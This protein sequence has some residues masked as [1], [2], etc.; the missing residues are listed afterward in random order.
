MISS[1]RKA[2]PWILVL[3]L[4]GCVCTVLAAAAAFLVGLLPGGEILSAIQLGFAVAYLVGSFLLF[5]FAR[6][7]QRIR[8][9]TGA[10]PVEEALEQQHKVLRLL[11]IAAL[12]QLALV[13]LVISAALFKELKEIVPP[14]EA[15]LPPAFASIGQACSP[16]AA[17]FVCAT[18]ALFN[19]Q[20]RLEHWTGW[21]TFTAD[22]GSFRMSPERDGGVRVTFQ[23][24]ESA[25]SWNVM[26]RPPW[27]NVLMRGAYTGARLSYGQARAEAGE[28]ELRTPHAWFPGESGQRDGQGWPGSCRAWE[29]TQRNPDARF[30]VREISWTRT[31]EPHRIT[32]DFERSCS[33][34]SGTWVVLGRVRAIAQ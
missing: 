10:A 33:S 19:A 13:T 29:F 27:G 22:Q 20:G 16:Q 12:I 28:L 4:L 11:G 18:I 17:D 21:Q 6:A 7:V 8:Q 25:G 14:G 32:V 30:T 23:S 2:H 31:G 1:L 24:T 15:A 34:E 5:A 9:G 26:V 3:G